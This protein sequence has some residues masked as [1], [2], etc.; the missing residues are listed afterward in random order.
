[1]RRGFTLMEILISSFLLLLVVMTLFALLSQTLRSVGH[2]DILIEAESLA[3]ESLAEA[4]AK[5][6]KELNLGKAPAETLGQFQ[7]QVEVLPVSGYD[8][9]QLRLIQVVVRWNESGQVSSIT[10]NL[11]YGGS[12]D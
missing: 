10:R 12:S 9:E 5:P 2:A 8:A 7:R 6:L 3:Q 1:M 11:H 4:R